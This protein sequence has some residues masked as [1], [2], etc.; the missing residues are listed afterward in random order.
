MVERDIQVPMQVMCLDGVVMT[1]ELNE[2]EQELTGTQLEY[3]PA[4]DY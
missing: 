2:N 4:L 3:G 1:S